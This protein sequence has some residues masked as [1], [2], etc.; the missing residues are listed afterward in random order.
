MKDSQIRA[1]AFLSLA[2]LLV[3]LGLRIVPAHWTSIWNDREF[4]GWVAPVANRLS[5]ESRLYEDGLHS[6]MPP[7]SFVLLRLLH[8][9]G[10]NWLAEST[11]NF[12]FQAA[13]ILLL[14][15]AFSKQLRFTVAFA[16]AMAA[17]PVFLALPK[18]ILYDSMAQFFVA[19]TGV[20]AA[21]LVQ[22]ISR[23]I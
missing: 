9:H 19:L 3:A 12:C 8:P 7:L 23:R 4:S 22:P 21:A 14:F 1:V 13:T 17:V 11:A 18:T 10:A 15:Y 20:I 5:V 16:A 6:P 2:I